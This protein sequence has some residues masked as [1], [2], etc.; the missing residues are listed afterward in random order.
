[1]LNRKKSAMTLAEIIIVIVIISIVGALFMS[2][3]KKNAEN[4]DKTRYYIAYNLLKRMQDEQAS[5]GEITL[6]GAGFR[7]NIERWL[8][9]S[10]EIITNGNIST[11]KLTNGM[12][13]NWD[14]TN[15][16]DDSISVTIDLDGGELKGENQDA[17]RFY[18]NNEGDVRPEMYNASGGVNIVLPFNVYGFDADGNIVYR[19]LNVN[20]NEA[21][22]FVES[23]KNNG[24]ENIIMEAVAPIK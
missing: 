18:L 12:T 20:Y 3:P 1:M 21:A 4:L 8:D 22:E 6:T 2:V 9:L 19:R 7:A 10:G 5:I 17:Y 15:D 24:E 14:T 23:A 13:I 11:A 16:N